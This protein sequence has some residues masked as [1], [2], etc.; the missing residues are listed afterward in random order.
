VSFESLP[1]EPPGTDGGPVLSR[2]VQQAV[3]GLP[4]QLK[5]VLF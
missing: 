5:R 2:H 4:E 1:E 3:D